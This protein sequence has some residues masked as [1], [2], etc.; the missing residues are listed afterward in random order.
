MKRTPLLKGGQG[1]HMSE[2]LRPYRHL[3]TGIRWP[4]MF[5]ISLVSLLI[6]VAGIIGHV[7]DQYNNPKHTI[8]T[9]PITGQKVEKAHHV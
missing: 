7:C 9:V 5:K 1:R 3:E 6:G 2:I 4:G 8:I